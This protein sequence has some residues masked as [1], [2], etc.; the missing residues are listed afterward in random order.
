L[1]SS[2]SGEKG[3]GFFREKEESEKEAK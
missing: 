1:F 3:L 2:A